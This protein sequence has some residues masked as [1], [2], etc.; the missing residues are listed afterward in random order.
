M[1]GLNRVDLILRVCYTTH[2]EVMMVNGNRQDN[3]IAFV[4]P[5][6][7]ERDRKLFGFDEGD[8][9]PISTAVN[10][11][12][13]DWMMCHLMHFAGF[14]PS[15]TS[16]RK[17]GWDKPIPAGFSEFIVGKRKKKVVILNNF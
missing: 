10:S 7:S 6:V 2:K 3:S 11:T 13:G 9:H 17:N 16:A 12:T 1:S 5:D 4:H 14:F 8:E 15:V